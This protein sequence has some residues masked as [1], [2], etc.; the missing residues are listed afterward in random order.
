[1]RDFTKFNSL[2]VFRALAALAVVVHHTESSVAHFVGGT[3]GWLDA[4]C[5]Y[6]YLGVDFFFVLSGFIILN[7]HID[8]DKSSRAL[9]AFG[10][11]RF[12]R[13]FPSYWPISIALLIS[14]TL[15]PG[16]SA[17]TRSHISILSS[18]LL[19]PD[20]SPPAL[21]VAW[22]LI[23]EMMFYL[24]FSLFF[25]STR[26]FIVFI[27]TWVVAIGLV[28]GTLDRSLLYPWAQRLLHPVNLE[29]VMGMGMAFVARKAK[30]GAALP[31]LCTGAVLLAVLVAAGFTDKSRAPFGL[32]FAAIVLGAVLLEK[33]TQLTFPRWLVIIGDAS[34]AIYLVHDPLVAL[35]SRVAKKLGLLS[36]W[37]T[38]IV[39]GVAVS[40]VAGLLYHLVYEKPVARFLRRS[41]HQAVVPAAG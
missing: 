24:I 19:L 10:F 13:I 9:R 21:K 38:G 14:Y 5:A 33:S 8:D 20:S 27:A 12:V 15:L 34:Y 32:A 1:M 17:G 40:L 26:L 41:R 35:T 37:S 25:V 36:H 39:F 2:Q 29:F 23:H 28:A 4:V 7:S 16:L 18:F 6:G 3:P 22:T 30:P 11:K 31:L